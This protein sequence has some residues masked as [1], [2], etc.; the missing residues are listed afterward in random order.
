MKHMRIGILIL[1][2]LQ[3]FTAPWIAH[4]NDLTVVAGADDR[5]HV[6]LTLYQ[7]GLAFIDES[8][9]VSVP[10]NFETLI[11]SRISPR[12]IPGSAQIIAPGLTVRALDYR[13][14]GLS[15]RALLTASVGK[16]VGILQVN[17]ATGVETI[18]R[19]DVLSVSDGIVLRIGDRI[20]TG[21]PG[22]MV[23]D[24]VPP[25]I[26]NSPAIVAMLQSGMSYDGVVGVQYLSDGLGWSADHII[27]VQEEGEQV[28]LDIESWA[29]IENNTG[30]SFDGASLALVAG[31][32]NRISQSQPKQQ[33][34]MEAMSMAMTD[35]P[36]MNLPAREELGDFH[37]YEVPGT[38]DL[39]DPARIQ[40]L[41]GSQKSI[42]AEKAYV[43]TG[44][45]QAYFG[46]VPGDQFT[47]EHPEIFYRF[48]NLSNEP[49]AGGMARLFGADS[50]NN[51]RFLGEDFLNPIAVSEKTKVHTGQAFDL[52]AR[53]RQLSFIRHGTKN[54]VFETSHEIILRNSSRR[55]AVIEVREQ[56]FGDWE[57]MESNHD[58]TRDGMMAVWKIDVPASGESVLRYRI[59]IKR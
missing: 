54:N 17:P 43:L 3:F 57:I 4:A 29:S 59:K 27:N 39:T 52:S 26:E 46:R 33:L 28:V 40:V 12:L 13:L 55:G 42:P 41:L 58:E 22:R 19:A 31:S 37:L 35:A 56:V 48:S 21:I 16:Q 18:V 1:L 47:A 25:D 30:V 24:N 9:R 45:G 49:L 5:N 34:R 44:H 50:Q 53:R 36:S 38:F 11:V 23:F 8:R 7:N 15:P 32:L 6:R 20:E 2:G 14:N 10:K 51:K